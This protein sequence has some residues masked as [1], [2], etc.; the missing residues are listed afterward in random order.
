MVDSTKAS[1][2]KIDDWNRVW[3]CCIIV[4]STFFVLRKRSHLL[5]HSY[6]QNHGKTRGICDT[7]KPPCIWRWGCFRGEILPGTK[8]TKIFYPTSTFIRMRTNCA[9]Q[10][11][12][13]PGS[14]SD[15]LLRCPEF[16]GWGWLKP[17]DQYARLLDPNETRMFLNNED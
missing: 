3:D 10:I 7:A 8:F 12:F 14:V 2:R 6:Y 16:L 4:K 15:P 1:C 13:G 11:L 5:K 17:P 9:I